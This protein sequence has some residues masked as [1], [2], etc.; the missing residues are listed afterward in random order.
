MQSH[1]D[2]AYPLF[3]GSLTSEGFSME[4][5]PNPGEQDLTEFL[6]TFNKPSKPTMRAAT[7][8]SRASDDKNAARTPEANTIAALKQKIQALQQALD[9]E[10]QKKLPMESKI[11]STNNERVLVQATTAK[12]KP[13][14]NQIMKFTL[15]KQKLLKKANP[16]ATSHA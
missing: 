8:T 15:K 10:Q 6:D 4:H 5:H 14:E 2:T 13:W 11:P 9:Y 7:I 12:R 16:N 1:D 3:M